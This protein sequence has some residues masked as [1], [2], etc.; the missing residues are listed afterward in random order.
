[1]DAEISIPPVENYRTQISAA[2]AYADDSHTVDDIAALVK[3]GKLQYWPGSDSVIIT[4]ITDQ[5]RFRSVHIVLAG[6]N[7]EELEAMLP[8][9]LDWGRKNGCSKAAFVGR[10]GWA[11]TFLT[12]RAGWTPKLWF[13]ERE[14]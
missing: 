6:G 9:V 10:R 2:L 1:M 14:L 4:E 11:K 7:L 5:P 12:K 13:F 3:Q 8:A